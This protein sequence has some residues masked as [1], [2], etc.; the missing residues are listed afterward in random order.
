MTVETIKDVLDL[1]R[2]LHINLA[3]ALKRASEET[4]QERLR[5]LLDYLYE[6]ESELGRVIA[7]S[8]KDAH[9]SALHTWCA[10]Y[11]DK[12]PFTPE[13]VE[14]ID[15]STMSTAAVM[16]SILTIHEQ[17]IDL[18]RYLSTRAVVTTAEEFLNFILTLEQHEAMRMV[19]DIEKLEDL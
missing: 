8:E 2:R 4:R 15:Y 11:I 13:A 14:N 10:E 16:Q 17:I 7:L 3:C 19:R 9:Q 12:Q 18:Y 1:T 5:M 6:H